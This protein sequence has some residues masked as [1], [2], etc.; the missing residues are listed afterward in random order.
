MWRGKS[1]QWNVGSWE[2][3]KKRPRSC[4]CLGI[5]YRFVSLETKIELGNRI[6]NFL[7]SDDM[8]SRSM[9]TTY[10]IALLFKNSTLKSSGSWLAAF[11]YAIPEVNSFYA[12]GRYRMVSEYRSCFTGFQNRSHTEQVLTREQLGS[13]LFCVA[14]IQWS[15]ELELRVSVS[16]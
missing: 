16:C 6:C 13:S 5:V 9:F 14:E 8:M 10:F 12:A 1:R 11:A 15:P 4:F 2:A 7:L 3:I